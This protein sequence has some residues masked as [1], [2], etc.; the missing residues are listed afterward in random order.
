MA[1]LLDHITPMSEGQR[2]LLEALKSDEYEIVGV[3]GPT[4]TGKS[5]LCALYGLDAVLSGKYRRFIIS[6]PIV[7]VVTGRE[8]TAI[9]AGPLY[10]E[11]FSAYLK[12]ILSDFIDW[13]K[14]EALLK[15]GRLVFADTHYLRG[16]TFD[17]SVVFVD[18]AQAARPES[19]I[20]VLMRVG[21]N[22]KFIVAGD[23]V[24]QVT[25][26][27]AERNGAIVLREVLLG[28]GRAKVIDLGL[29]DVVRPGAKRGIRLLMEMLMRSRQL[30]DLEKRVLEIAKIYAPDADIVT[31]LD[32]TEDK[33]T[34][35]I[36][37]EHT[38]DVL[39][40]VKE[41]YLARLIGK[42]GERIT[43]IQDE[44]GVKVRA[45]ELT[46]N[47][48]N[49][50]KAVHP[51]SWIHK[52]VVD[53]DFAGPFLVIKVAREFG[54]FVGQKGFHVKFISSALK[55]LININAIAQEAEELPS[56][57]E[58]VLLEEAKPITRRRKRT[59]S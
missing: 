26:G 44:A 11:L 33:E 13:K 1:E 24:L 39:I 38:P 16:R 34:F 29:K 53:A 17:N 9:E 23:P 30:N 15:E 32:L 54:A 4:G 55:K 27:I 7:D 31:I 10:H 20:E 8:I 37:S 59:R 57:E 47:F 2:M 6:R 14:V 36:E 18:D 51:V 28:E 5:L 58:E 40:I 22:S 35:E 42:G 46:L 43:K 48:T 52:H 25:P 3:F 50:I 49:F 12:D 41:G 45:I 19:A 21:R 56:E